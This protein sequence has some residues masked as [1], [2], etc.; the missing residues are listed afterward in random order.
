MEVLHIEKKGQLLN[1]LKRFH[2]YNVSKRKLQMN[3][4]YQ[5]THNPIFHFDTKH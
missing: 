3:D 5:D 1:T 4:T 2:I